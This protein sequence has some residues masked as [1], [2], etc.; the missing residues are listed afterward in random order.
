V[1][2]RAPVRFLLL[3]KHYKPVS[4]WRDCEHRG[5]ELSSHKPCCQFFAAR[6]A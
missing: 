5:N 6:I 2:D 4:R 3:K 1:S